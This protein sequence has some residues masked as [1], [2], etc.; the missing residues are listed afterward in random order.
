MQL[1]PPPADLRPW[2][3]GGVIVRTPAALGRS[4]FPARV[5]GQLVLRLG[6]SVRLEGG[7]DEP[8]TLA[9]PSAS[10][11]AASAAPTCFLHDGDVSAIG[12]ILRPEAAAGW[13]GPVAAELTGGVA[14]LDDLAGPRWRGLL[15]A[16]QAAGDDRAR[17]Q[18]LFDAL[19]RSVAGDARPERRRA[20]ALRL[21]QEARVA[22]TE[23]SAVAGGRGGLPFGQRQLQRQFRRTYGLG[24]KQFQTL[25]RLRGVLQGAIQDG[26]GAF[27]AGAALAQSAGYFDQAH[28]ARDLRRLAGA[29]L[30]ELLRQAR[31]PAQGTPGEHWPL[32]I[33]VAAG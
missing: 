14:A 28:L 25:C 26:A 33:G 13:L 5:T 19:R 29:P 15:D 18:L 23:P 7:P 16:V 6:G 30:T 32:A 10:Y 11:I 3:E 22:A 4:C 2:I 27:G 24:P 1:I 21:L 17:L 9:L 20:Q 31:A 8:G 12:L